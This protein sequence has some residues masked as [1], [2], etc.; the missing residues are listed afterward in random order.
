MRLPLIVPLVLYQGAQ[1]WQHE[2]EF[3]ALFADVAPEWRWVP[4]F[5]HVLIDQTRQSPDSVP[6]GLAAR[7][8]QVAMMAA[9][10]QAREDL[11]ESATRLMGELYRAMGFDAVTK[12]VE[13]VLATQPDE[14][15]SVF[16]DALRR[17]V[18]GRGGDVMNYVEQ[19]IERGRREGRQEGR[20]EGHR[21]GKLEGRLEGKLEGQIRTIEGL[22]ERDLSWPIIEAATG[23]DEAAFRRFKRQL[24]AAED[25]DT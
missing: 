20:Q 11:L 12:H 4:R 10:R 6:G 13:Y 22:L 1:P 8:A 19:L 9:F 5:E 18:P 21:E 25:G 15:R 24:D 7:L 16:V 23:I 3:A 2:R 14:Y 17:N